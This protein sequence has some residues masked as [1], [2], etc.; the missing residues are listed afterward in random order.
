MSC[1]A[2]FSEFKCGSVTDATFVIKV[3]A[4]RNKNILASK[5]SKHI[6]VIFLSIFVAVSGYRLSMNEDYVF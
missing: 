1:S 2:E 5:Y 6:C 4:F 3:E